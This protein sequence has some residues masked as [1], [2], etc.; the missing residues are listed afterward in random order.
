MGDTKVHHF[1]NRNQLGYITQL[2]LTNCCIIWS[3]KNNV[4]PK[5]ELQSNN[6]ISKTFSKG[7]SKCIQLLNIGEMVIIIFP[8]VGPVKGPWPCSWPGPRDLWLLLLLF[9]SL[10][11]LYSHLPHAGQ[12]SNQPVPKPFGQLQ[13]RTPGMTPTPTLTTSRWSAIAMLQ[14]QQQHFRVGDIKIFP[15]CSNLAQTLVATPRQ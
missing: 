5:C 15:L 1:Y 12:P 8:S 9:I 4:L 7:N 13:T 11:P 14:Q 10:S 6:L 3:I 2:F